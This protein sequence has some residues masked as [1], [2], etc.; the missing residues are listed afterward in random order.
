MHKVTAHRVLV[1][2]TVTT[3]LSLT[4]SL[5]LQWAT[6]NNVIF[7]QSP[8]RGQ[9]KDLKLVEIGVLLR[10]TLSGPIQE[11]DSWC[12]GWK[13]VTLC[14]AHGALSLNCISSYGILPVATCCIWRISSVVHVDLYFSFSLVEFTVLDLRIWTIVRHL[15]LW[16]SCFCVTFQCD[17]TS[18]YTTHICW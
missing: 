6:L 3:V 12:F 14:K 16:W 7:C 15:R 11:L 17:C 4:D 13:T 9:S 5:Q 1:T 18:S 8:Y 2:C 10:G